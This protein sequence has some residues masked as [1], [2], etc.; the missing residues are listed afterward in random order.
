MSSVTE[1]VASGMTGWASP[2]RSTERASSTACTDSMAPSG[3]QSRA[4]MRCTASSA[5]TGTPESPTCAELHGGD[6]LKVCLQRGHIGL[7]ERLDSRVHLPPDAVGDL[8]E[9]LAVVELGAGLRC[10]AASTSFSICATSGL[11]ESAD[12]R[13]LRM[14]RLGRRPGPAGCSVPSP[15]T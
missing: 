7:D 15:S 8:A 3:D 4:D 13:A 10:V 9:R 2:V 5:T 1:I 6:L 14:A 12:L 11:P